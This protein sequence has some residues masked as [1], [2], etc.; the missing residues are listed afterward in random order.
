MSLKT[1]SQQLTE[2]QISLVGITELDYS[3]ETAK[4]TQEMF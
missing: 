2:H 3:D 1:F 4:I